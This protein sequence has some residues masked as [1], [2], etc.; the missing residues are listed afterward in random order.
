MRNLLLTFSTLLLL[1]NAQAQLVNPGFES[2]EGA[3]T[4]TYPTAWQWIPG[5]MEWTKTSD[6]R[7][8]SFALEVSVW[9]YYTDT[10]AEPMTANCSK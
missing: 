10:K 5:T 2:W 8:G 4:G 7:S 1:T 9:Y 6:A 3:G